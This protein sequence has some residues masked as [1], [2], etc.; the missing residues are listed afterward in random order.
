MVYTLRST[1]DCDAILNEAERVARS[2]P[3]R[4]N[5]PKWKETAGYKPIMLKKHPNC[6]AVTYAFICNDLIAVFDP[7]TSA[8]KFLFIKNNSISYTYLDMSVATLSISGGQMTKQI[9]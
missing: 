7:L 6:A 2:Q 1:A 5:R 4:T 9:W 3:R 8:A